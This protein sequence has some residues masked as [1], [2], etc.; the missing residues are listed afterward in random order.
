MLDRIKSLHSNNVGYALISSVLMSTFVVLIA[1]SINFLFGLISIVLINIA[2]F[3]DIAIISLGVSF[4]YF[5]RSNVKDIASTK[6]SVAMSIIIILL[7]MVVLW[8]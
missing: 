1:I 8:K 4:L 6:Y 3:P 7:V 2:Y 5:Y